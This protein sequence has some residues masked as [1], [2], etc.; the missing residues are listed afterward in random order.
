[1]KIQFI[2]FLVF[3][4][5][6]KNIQKL[7]VGE[8]SLTTINPSSPYGYFYFS[9]SGNRFANLVLL[10]NNFLLNFT[11]YCFIYTEYIPTYSDIKYCRFYT[12]H[13][14]DFRITSS[15]KEYYFATKI[16]IGVYNVIIRYSGKNI[17]GEIKASVVYSYLENVTPD[18]N[19]GTKLSKCGNS[20]TYFYTIISNSSSDYIYFNLLDTY[21]KTQQTLYYCFTEYNPYNHYLKSIRSCNFSPMNY[22]NTGNTSYGN[23]DCYYKAN[24]ISYSGY[25]ILVRYKYNYK[26]GVIYVKSS[27]SEIDKSQKSTTRSLST[28]C[29]IFIALAGLAFIGIIIAIVCYYCRKKEVNNLTYTP[30][31]SDDVMAA[32]ASNFVVNEDNDYPSNNECYKS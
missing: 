23:Y 10:D 1:M 3:I 5:Y 28:L 22:Y 26:P 8:T 12:L 27:Y 17:N 4:I 11:S 25:Y 31:E 14:F 2:L 21:N 20:D 7:K 16:N 24:I 6:S 19:Y 18:S 32:P 30:S 15:G 9:G 13:D 29:I